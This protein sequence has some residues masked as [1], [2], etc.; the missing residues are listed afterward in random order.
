MR[1][2]VTDIDWTILSL[3]AL[4]VG[5]EHTGRFRLGGNELLT[6]ADGKS[7]ITYEDFSIAL[8][9]KSNNR[10]TF[11]KGLR[12][13]LLSRQLH[14]ANARNETQP[15]TASHRCWPQDK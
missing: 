8:L 3:S 11:E 14:Y 5:G 10:N 7:W 2:P 12:F 6:A 15:Q 13:R 4:F 9:K 1:R